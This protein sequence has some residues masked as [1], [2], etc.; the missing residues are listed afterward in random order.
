MQ[1]RLGELASGV[2]V[3]I[4]RDFDC[5]VCC[6]RIS[7]GLGIV[8]PAQAIEI[9]FDLVSYHLVQGSVVIFA[10]VAFLGVPGRR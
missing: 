8:N 5:Q 4:R 7:D 2:A 1:F 10:D 9:G 3:L 6:F